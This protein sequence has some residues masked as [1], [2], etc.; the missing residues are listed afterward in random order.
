[1]N[2]F[3][4]QSQSHNTFYYKNNTTENIDETN[5]IVDVHDNV[6]GNLMIDDN[7]EDD[8]TEPTS[9]EPTSFANTN[10]CDYIPEEIECDTSVV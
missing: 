5:D 4:S 9:F 8:F 7:N 3:N 10:D 1:M 6:D 2:L